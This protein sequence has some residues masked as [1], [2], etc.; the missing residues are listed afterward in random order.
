MT[1]ELITSAPIVPSFEMTFS[2]DYISAYGVS[3]YLQSKIKVSGYAS[4]DFN[5]EYN[6]ITLN[7]D[8]NSVAIIKQLNLD[9]KRLNYPELKLTENDIFGTQ[10][11]VKIKKEMKYKL[12]KKDYTLNL[13]C[14]LSIFKSKKGE[15]FV[16]LSV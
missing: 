2:K 3:T 9:L 15:V 11:F 13:V 10:I 7:L 4:F 14:S 6:T 5:A 1:T 8:E 12:V 16:S